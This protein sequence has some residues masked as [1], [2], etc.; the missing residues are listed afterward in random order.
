MFSRAKDEF[1]ETLDAC[2]FEEEEGSQQML[3]P[4]AH[5]LGYFHVKTHKSKQKINRTDIE[6]IHTL[7]CK[8]N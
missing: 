1:S 5:E 4:T 6:S 3:T 2:R 8:I 7:I